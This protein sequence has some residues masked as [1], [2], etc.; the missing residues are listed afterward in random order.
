MVA[1]AEGNAR[2]QNDLFPVRFVRIRQPHGQDYQGVADLLGRIVLLTALLPLLL[3]QYALHG[4]N[5][6]G[7]AQGA[8]PVMGGGVRLVQVQLDAGQALQ[9]LLQFLV[10]IVPAVP[11]FLQEGLKF[12]L[13][14]QYQLFEAVG[15]QL[16][17][18]GLYIAGG[19]IQ[20]DLQPI[21]G[22]FLRLSFVFYPI[23]L[24]EEK[25]RNQK[26]FNFSCTTFYLRR[27]VV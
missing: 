23:V 4:G 9:F 26:L 17:S 14:L 5:A 19:G 27:M 16:G 13:V 2:V 24:H 22:N 25:N 11:V 21:H 15:G 20:G 1:G 12:P 6:V 7:G 8:E 18:Q 10:D 3:G